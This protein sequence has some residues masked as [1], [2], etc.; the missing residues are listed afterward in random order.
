M[1]RIVAHLIVGAKAEPFLAAM[2]ASIEPVV[3]RIFVNENSGLGELAPNLAALEASAFFRGGRMTLDRTS[4]WSFAAARNAC[5]ALDRAANDRTWVT[6]IDGDEVH[7]ACLGRVA[8]NLV[9]LPRS[10]AFVDGYTRHFFKSFDWYL[11]IERRMM[12][13]RWRAGGRWEGDVHER[14]AG[15]DGKRV[16]V[17]YVYA[18]YGH[19]SPFLEDTRQGAQYAALGQTGNAL[20]AEIARAADLQGDFTELNPHFAARWR[21]VIRFKG[22]HPEPARPIITYEKLSRAAHFQRIEE[23][24]RGH[25]SASQRA[26]NALLNLNYEQRWRL[27]WFEATR[28]GLLRP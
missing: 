20:P 25:Q 5:L 11:S 16:A 21:R 7:D 6:F 19:V 2:L 8:R 15:L 12:F 4:F 27:R 26:K 23:A 14:L 18:H 13:F 1:P 24:I 3:E 17:P 9:R 22:M 10:V 28:Y